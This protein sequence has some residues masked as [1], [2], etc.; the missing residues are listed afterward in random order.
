MSDRDPHEPL[1]ADQLAAISELWGRTGRELLVR[2]TGSSMAPALGS[3]T[4]VKLACGSG[5]AVGDV[6]AVRTG[7]TVIVHRVVARSATGAWIVTRGD[8]RLLPD[9]PATGDAVIGLVSSR[10]GPRGFEDVPR[11]APSLAQRAALAPLVTLLR[12]SPRAGTTVIAA[13]V[14]LRR[15]LLAGV[16]ALRRASPPAG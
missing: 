4:E 3:E 14:G 16:G 12:V 6:V 2:F 7:G 11:T 1:P 13:L 5:G 10:R 9:M 15:R 8:A